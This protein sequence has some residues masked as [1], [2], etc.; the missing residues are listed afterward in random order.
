M[1]PRT[2]GKQSARVVRM[3]GGCGWRAVSFQNV[4]FALAPRTFVFR[5]HSSFEGSRSQRTKYG[6]LAR[7]RIVRAQH[8]HGFVV[9]KYQE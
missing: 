7:C 4:A 1:A 6:V 2:F 5:V 8:V 3:E 9:L